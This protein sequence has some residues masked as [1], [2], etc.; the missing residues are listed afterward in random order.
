MF[1]VALILDCP[2]RYRR[3]GSTEVQG[4]T[5]IVELSPE[6]GG[7]YKYQEKKKEVMKK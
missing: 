2:K 7:L 6:M 5:K 1:H 4:S 3:I